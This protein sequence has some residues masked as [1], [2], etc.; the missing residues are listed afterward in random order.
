MAG[1]VPEPLT[2]MADGTVKQLNPFSGTEVW[3]VPGRA[4]RPL[5]QPPAQ[6]APLGPDAHTMTCAFC[7]GRLA[8]TPPEKARITAGELLHHPSPT[9]ALDPGADFRRIP[10]LFEIVSFDYW[11]RNYD[12]DLSPAA[13]HRLAEWAADPLGRR[14]IADLTR[15]RTRASHTDAE[16][17]ALSE[18][19]RLDFARGFFGGCHDVIVARR[20][21]VD[22]AETDSE[23]A[24]AGCLTPAE[25]ADYITLTIDALRDIYATNRYVRYVQVF[26]NWLA[27]AGASFDHL[28]KQL[29]GID[30]RGASAEE[31]I[32]R[33][34]AEPNMYNDWAI[35]YAHRRNLVVAANEHAVAFAGFGHRFPSLEVYSRARAT[36]PWEHSPAQRRGMSDLLHALHAAAG[37]H[38]PC[39]EEWHHQ[40]PDAITPMPWR[41]VIKWRVSTLAGF[42][43]GTKIYTN[44]IDPWALRDRVTA[45][46]RD[47]RAADRLAPGIA[48]AE[49]CV[50]PVNP[51]RYNA[52]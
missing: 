38:L 44:T 25:H 29:V 13:A 47:L 7:P 5:G 39:N 36:F 8:E 23:L 42:E 30:E 21:F 50:I 52:R 32:R 45:H 17:E 24:S 27:P 14:R 26:Q 48:I 4:H 28:H 40:P 49:E 15:A 19:E 41:I 31:E 35:N 9:Q 3:T 12:Y 10:N 33:V 46:L 20:H 51:L 43:G 6:A 16:W 18:A 1:L 37:A 34:S 2:V 11:R 22:G